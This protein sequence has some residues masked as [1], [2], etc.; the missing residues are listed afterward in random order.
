MR[1]TIEKHVRSAVMFLVAGLVFGGA[2]PARAETEFTAKIKDAMKTMK[3]EATKLGEPKVEGS[4]L[5]FGTTK[6]NG[7]YQ[8]VDAIKEK[9]GCTATFFVK[10]GTDFVRVS[11]NVVKEGNRAVGTVLDPKGPA[12]A[13]I[14]KGEA[15]YGLADILGT[16]YDTGYEPIKNAAG[17]TVGVYYIGYPLK[18]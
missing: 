1:S 12:I 13:Q 6:M 17:E 16:Q 2:L 5:L 10:K 11:T 7:N 3:E 4:A 8:I 14:A 18:K 15:Y 9:F